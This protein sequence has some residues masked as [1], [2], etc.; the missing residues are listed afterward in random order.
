MKLDGSILLDADQDRVWR[1]LLDVNEISAC[2]PGV[3]SVVQIDERTFDG[4]IEATV[5][6]ISG[7]FSFRA[8]LLE[9]N[10]PTELLA[11]IEGAD[12]ITKSKLIAD[13]TA[14]LVPLNAT[15]TEIRYRSQ[16]NVKGR[17]AILGEMVLRATAVAMLDEVAERLRARMAQPETV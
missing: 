8:N 16:V 6:P 13:T 3:Q 15:Q 17:L 2:I 10:P 11:H 4:L 12:S 5:G 7:K 1:T 9:S 14:V